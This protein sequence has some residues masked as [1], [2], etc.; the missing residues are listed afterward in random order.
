MKP[1]IITGIFGIIAIA[2]AAEALNVAMA[3]GEFSHIAAYNAG[4]F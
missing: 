3:L 4:V 1:M 2:I